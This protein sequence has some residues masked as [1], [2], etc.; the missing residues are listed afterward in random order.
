MSEAIRMFL[1]LC[2]AGM[3]IS[4]SDPE[5]IRK[6]LLAQDNIGIVSCYDSLH[7]ANQSYPEH[8]GV[9]DVMHY[10]DLGRYKR[11]IKP[12]IIWDQLPLLVPK[13]I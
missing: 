10:D 6:R 2:A 4:I 1:G 5:D 3:P 7:R 9:H 11:R 12:F 8:Q 13:K